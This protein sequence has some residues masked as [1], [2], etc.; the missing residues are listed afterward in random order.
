L[1]IFGVDEVAIVGD[2]LYGI[3]FCGIPCKRANAEY[4]GV[5]GDGGE[6]FINLI[7]SKSNEVC[8]REDKRTISLEH[9]LKALECHII[10][11]KLEA[12]QKTFRSNLS[13][14]QVYI[15]TVR[16]SVPTAD[17]YIAK[18]LATVEDFALLHEDKIYSE[19]KTCVCYI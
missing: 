5:E 18:K 6:E 8:S 1:G 14:S 19:S 16:L 7:S 15:P 11:A 17:V 4:D 3:G 9:V 2:L 12:A 13:R 10:E